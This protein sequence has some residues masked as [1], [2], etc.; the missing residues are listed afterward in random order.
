MP[1]S[2]RLSE[3]LGSSLSGH[4]ATK[5]LTQESHFKWISIR[6]FLYV[7][8]VHASSAFDY[9]LF[10]KLLHERIT[11]FNFTFA[12]VTIGITYMCADLFI[13]QYTRR[14]DFNQDLNPLI[15]GLTVS[16]L[17]QTT[18]WNL[19]NA[20]DAGDA[21]RYLFTGLGGSAAW[22][23]CQRGLN[24]TQCISPAEL[25]RRCAKRDHIEVKIT[26][27][28]LNYMRQFETEDR[29]IITTRF[30]VSA[31]V[32]TL[33]FL[34][35][36]VTD[37]SILKLYKVIFLATNLSTV[38]TLGFLMIFTNDTMRALLQIMDFNDKSGHMRDAMQEIALVYGVGMIGIYDLGT[39]S[40]FTMPDNTVVIFTVVYTS[41][42]LMRSMI[43]RIM[44]LSMADCLIYDRSI[45]S[46]HYLS[47]VLLPLSTEFLFGKKLHAIYIYAN[48]A[49]ATVSYLTLFTL[50][51]SK[52]LH[53]QFRTIKSVY[54]V[55][56]LCILGFCLSA[57]M[58]MLPS[59]NRVRNGLR[60][61][62][63]TTLFYLA[64]MR[65]ALIMWGYGV[66]RFSTDIQFWLGYKPTCF[67]TW[68]WKVLP[69]VLLVLF[70]DGFMYLTT[71]ETIELVAGVCWLMLSILISAIFQSKTIAYYVV[72]NN[73]MGAF[74]AKKKYGPPDPED[75][76]QRR[77][78]NVHIYHRKCL[79]NCMILDTLRVI[80]Y[81]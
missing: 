54:I 79:H 44:Y 78:Y 57:P 81:H 77:N 34:L 20:R 17:I 9:D 49:I 26:S 14:L 24:H 28:H 76:Q 36:T 1:Y 2:R 60:Y 8:F 32:W 31:I 72:E 75:R 11:L 55:G 67:W 52:I 25:V 21:V 56:L 6:K 58:L 3:S 63:Y 40:P 37:D 27:A 4:L 70:V 80:I 69:A 59:W 43:V 71:L 19:Y 33:N 50:T 46:S 74:R 13:K 39:M 73:L 61:G 29:S 48:R 12:A 35:S 38:F 30:F 66:E 45:M 51:M 15:K 22:S 53:M 16:I 23:Q 7:A 47:F 10:S 42:A 18:F 65:M 5:D 41:I 64:G 62:F 68:S